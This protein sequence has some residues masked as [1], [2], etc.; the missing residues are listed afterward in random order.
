MTAPASQLAILLR[1]GDLPGAANA[2]GRL[3]ANRGLFA[4]LVRHGGYDTIHWQVDQR[5]SQEASVLARVESLLGLAAQSDGGESRPR[6]ALASPLNTQPATRAGILLHGSAY[7]GGAAWLRRHAG[8][9]RHYSVV[10]SFFGIAVAA[11]RHQMLGSLLAPLQPWDAVICAS[12]TVQRAVG[13]MFEN[14]GAYLGER[15]GA[16]Q[17][18]LPQL[19]VIPIGV[20]TEAMAAWRADSAARRELRQ[21]LGIDHNAVAVLWVGRLSWFDKAFPQPMLLALEL[22]A[23]RSAVPVHWLVVGWFPHAERDRPRFEEAARVHAPTVRMHLLDGNDQALVRRCWAAADLFLSLSDTILETFGQAP[24]EAM[25]AGLPVVLSDWDGYRSL[26]HNGREGVLIPSLMPPAA[27]NGEWLALMQA[28]AMLEPS[29]YG[30]S[31]AQHVAVHVGQAA[32]ALTALIAS[33]ELR[34]CLGEAAQRRARQSF[35]WPVVVAAHQA[36]FAELNE[37]RQHELGPSSAAPAQALA[38]TPRR[39]TLPPLGHD[40]FADFA[41]YATSCLSDSM[42][43]HCTPLQLQRDDAELIDCELDGLLPGLRS[44]PAEL[45]QLLQHLRNTGSCSVAELLE[46]LPRQRQPFARLGLVWLAKL[47][48]IDWLSPEAADPLACLAQAQASS[49]QGSASVANDTK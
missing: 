36:L 16:R 6:F 45:Q 20:D 12:P 5:L 23:Q 25:A 30:G 10:G 31:V 35:A 4:A 19:P 9:E 24:V 7:V 39:L 49:N 8:L 27:G 22:A 41:G 15:T 3:V 42:E 38:I 28:M 29:V 21:R 1:S 43:L 11:A 26:L 17:L 13:T 40:P 18:P 44:T 32:A 2:Y 33:A 47:G 37:W 48:R 34:R 46:I 14:M